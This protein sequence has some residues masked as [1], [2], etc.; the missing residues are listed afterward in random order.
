M[1]PPPICSVERNPVASQP[2]A[3]PH[4]R[5]SAHLAARLAA[6]AMLL[7]TE[8]RNSNATIEKYQKVYTTTHFERAGLAVVDKTSNMHKI[9]NT[10]NSGLPDNHISAIAIDEVGSLWI[11][12]N[13]GGLVHFKDSTWTVYN[14]E[15]SGL[16]NDV[17]ASIA[18]DNTGS[19]WIGT[20]FGGLAKFDGK[21][22]AVYNTND[23]RLPNNK[24]FPI[25][26]DAQGNIWIGTN[27]GGLAVY[28]QAGMK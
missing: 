19:L 9:L 8:M 1:S 22:W 10:S 2:A 16:P 24:I 28:H 27:G 14:T 15:N 12:T 13:G 26:I 25:V 5:G 20:Y 4:L 23:S 21:N 18:I 3:S 7:G 11:G 17:I 6:V